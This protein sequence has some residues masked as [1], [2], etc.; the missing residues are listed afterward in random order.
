MA[1][2]LLAEA[3]VKPGSRV[4]V[5][6]GSGG[7]GTNLVQLAKLK[8]ASFVATTST[9]AELMRTLGADRVI[10]YST[11]NWWEVAEFAA[12]KFD[13]IFDLVGGKQSWRTA[14]KKRVLKRTGRYITLT[15]DHRYMVMH[16]WWDAVK[17]GCPL[18]WRNVWTKLWP[19]VPKYSMFNGLDYD[20]TARKK[21]FDLVHEK[22]VQV[23]LDPQS[24]F[25][26]TTEGVKAA[27]HLQKSYHA[28]GKV[29][30]KIDDHEA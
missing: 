13:V 28:K 3:A 15:G 27:Y 21:L 11:E 10:D 23:V 25:P 20:P 18:L 26:F 29:V 9:A 7:V 14:S 4:L 8:G 6:G 24:P 16:S 30:V 2:M 22:N 17:W 19:G 12:E 5:L 1:A